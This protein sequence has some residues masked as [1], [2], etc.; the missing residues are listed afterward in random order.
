VPPSGGG[1]VMM[2]AAVY[3]Q[4]TKLGIEFPLH[5]AMNTTV[6][7]RHAVVYLM[8]SKSTANQVT[9]YKVGSFVVRKSRSYP[10]SYALAVKVS[11][12]NTRPTSRGE[13]SIT[14]KMQSVP[15]IAEK[16]LL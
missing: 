15:A 2:L 13:H 14:N 1:N 4:T 5:H 10:G 7:V 11:P 9:V 16:S 12:F 3:L 8:H 6:R